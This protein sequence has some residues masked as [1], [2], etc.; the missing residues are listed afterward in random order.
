M[1]QRVSSGLSR[2]HVHQVQQAGGG[3][4]GVPLV[5]DLRE[6]DQVGVSELV[7]QISRAEGFG[8]AWLRRRSVQD[9]LAHGSLEPTALPLKRGR[10][11]PAVQR[12]FQAGGDVAQGGEV[13]DQLAVG[14][15]AHWRDPEHRSAPAFAPFQQQP[16]ILP[17][18]RVPQCHIRQGRTVSRGQRTQLRGA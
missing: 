16:G 1:S 14:G 15:R 10:R 7:E 18:H 13:S 5:I 6:L 2:A 12:A 4:D 8:L 3:H 9:A 17:A 11:G